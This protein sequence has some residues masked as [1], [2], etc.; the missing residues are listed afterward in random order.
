METTEIVRLES[1][2]RFRFSTKIHD[3]KAESAKDRVQRKPRKVFF[4]RY[5]GGWWSLKDAA[6]TSSRHNKNWR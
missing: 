3:W 6:A 5:L 2:F 1:F 4:L